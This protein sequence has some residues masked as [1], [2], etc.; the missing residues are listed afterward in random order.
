MY[1]SQKRMV[2]REA[3]DINHQHVCILTA[4]DQNNNIYIEPVTSGSPKSF[5]VYDKLQPR[6]SK[7]AVL[8]TDEHNSYKYF[9]RKEMIEHIKQTT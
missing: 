3:V 2:G 9:C 8:V 7:D 5:D 4:I 6:L 1:S